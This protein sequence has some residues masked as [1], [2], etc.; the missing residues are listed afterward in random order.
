M[1]PWHYDQNRH[2]KPQNSMSPMP[3]SIATEPR[4]RS[5]QIPQSLLLA[6]PGFSTHRKK[7]FVHSLLALCAESIAGRRIRPRRMM[8][9]L[10]CYKLFCMATQTDND[11]YTK[12]R[13]GTLQ[14]S[15]RVVHLCAL[16]RPICM[17][18]NTKRSCMH[19]CHLVRGEFERHLSFSC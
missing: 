7:G 19:V 4:D 17:S 14:R 12:H 16:V 3:S 9:V 15:N 1:I 11:C 18:P 6:Q 10:P 8:I 5:V 2:S 13:K